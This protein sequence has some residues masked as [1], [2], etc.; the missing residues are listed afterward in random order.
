MIRTLFLLKNLLLIKHLNHFILIAG[1]MFYLATQ[2][3][4]ENCLFVRAG[5]FTKQLV[6]LKNHWFSSQS[7]LIEITCCD[8]PH[9]SYRFLITYKFLNPHYYNLRFTI[10]QFADALTAIPSVTFLYN[11]ANWLEREVWDMFGLFFVN[12]PDLRR[13]LTDY[14]F[15]GHALRKDFP[16][17]GFYEVFFNEA[18]QLVDYQRISL[19][20]EFRDFTTF[21]NPWLK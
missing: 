20:Q 12:H 9:K 1:K 8:Y 17:S 10:N 15:V 3:H 5:S 21:S 7:Q 14:G 16:L 13:I 6:I 4:Y 2:D 18:I 11:S 19:A